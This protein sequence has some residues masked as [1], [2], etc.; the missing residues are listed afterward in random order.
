MYTTKF[1][2]S[3]RKFCGFS[4]LSLKI[5]QRKKVFRFG[6]EK[7]KVYG[8]CH[9]YGSRSSFLRGVMAYTVQSFPLHGVSTLS[10]SLRGVMVH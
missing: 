4:D 10:H 7:A 6:R 1:D 2:T 9:R 8:S 3:S 5:Q